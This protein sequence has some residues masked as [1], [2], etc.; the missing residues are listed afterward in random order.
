LCVMGMVLRRTPHY[1]KNRKF[2]EY[3]FDFTQQDEKTT[4]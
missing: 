3:L 4:F 2:R 1:I